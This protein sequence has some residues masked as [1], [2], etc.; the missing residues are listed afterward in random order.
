MLT[1][2]DPYESW[3]LETQCENEIAQMEETQKIKFNLE[4]GEESWQEEQYF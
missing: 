2:I 1:V 3:D 4:K